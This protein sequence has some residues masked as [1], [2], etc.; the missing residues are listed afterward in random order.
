MNGNGESQNLNRGGLRIPEFGVNQPSPQVQVVFTPSSFP[1][2]PV[3]AAY[4]PPGINLSQAKVFNATPIQPQSEN[5][6]QPF[7]LEI[8]DVHVAQNQQGIG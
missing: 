8:K 4:Q 5:R 6:F 1:N 7:D 3:P 2:P